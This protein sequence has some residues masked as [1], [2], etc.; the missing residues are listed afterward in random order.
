MWSIKE[1]FTV[2]ANHFAM[3]V[4]RSGQGE[5]TFLYG[6]GYHIIG[7]YNEL[8]GVFNFV[9]SFRNGQIRSSAGDMMIAKVDQGTIM[10]FECGG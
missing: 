6:P 9:D 8:V 7:Y 3:V 1:V 4:H 10:H 5:I 2:K